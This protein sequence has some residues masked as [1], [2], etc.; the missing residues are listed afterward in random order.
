M[1]NGGQTARIEMHS[2]AGRV[3]LMHAPWRIGETGVA[4]SEIAAGRTEAA[5]NAAFTMNDGSEP[6]NKSFHSQ[7]ETSLQAHP[8]HLQA[9]DDS[10]LYD[11]HDC[12]QESH[13]PQV[14]PPAIKYFGL[15]LLGF[16]F[17]GEFA[18]GRYELRCHRCRPSQTSHSNRVH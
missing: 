13:D 2:I 1:L 7:R 18:D 16:E 9:R 14:R 5:A 8:R 15:H 11:Q 6:V 3:F 17:D 10:L 12:G 4:D